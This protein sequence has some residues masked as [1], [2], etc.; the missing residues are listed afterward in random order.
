MRK[1][2]MYTSSLIVSFLL[3]MLSP[4]ASYAGPNASA[5]CALDMDYASREYDPGISTTDI[6]SSIEAAADDEIWIAVVAQNV[7]NLDTYQVEV[8]FDINRIAFLGGFEDNPSE[9]IYNLL[10]NNGE[11][12]IGF[13]AVENVP[14]TVMP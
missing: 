9:G 13:Q 7:T 10:K 6:E 4:P 14:G 12:T 11:T 3:C 8:S 2:I 1:Q 5:G